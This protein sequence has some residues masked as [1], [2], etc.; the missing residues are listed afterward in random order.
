MAMEL[1]RVDMKNESTVATELPKEWLAIGGSGLIAKIM[2]DE[3]PSG[4][5]PLGPDNKLVIACGPLAGTRAPQLGRISVGAK[6][7]L[8]LGIKEA[9]A[10]GPAGQHMDRLGFRAIVV[11]NAAKQEKTFYLRIS[12]KGARL[13]PA[14]ELEGLKNYELV[15]RLHSR[16]GKKVAIVCIG[17][18]GERKYRGAS[19]SFTDI[20]GDPSRN[21]ARGGLGAVMGSKGLKAI[22]LDPAGTLPLNIADPDRFKKTVKSWVKTMA[23]D[24]SCGLYSKYG[25]PFA[26][27]NSANQG[28]LPTLNYRSGRPRDFYRISG[29]AIQEILFKRGGRM[30]GCMPGCVVKCSIIY[31]D[32]EGNRLASAYE[33]ET[34]AMLGAN[35]GIMDLDAIGRLKFMCDDL[36]LDAIEIGSCLG[37]AADAGK[38]EMGDSAAAAELLMEI[39][40]GSAFGRALGNGVV[41]TAKALNV[42]RVPAYKGQ[43]FPGH[44]PRS[45]KGTGVTYLTSPMGADHTAGLT[46]RIPRQKEKQAQNS[47]R[48]QV[49]AATCDTFGYCL[50]SVP[51]GQTSIYDFFADLMNA[52]YG[53]ELTRDDIVEIGKQTLRDQI[54]F[55]ENAEFSETDDF[56]QGFM[57]TESLGPSDQVFDV[58]DKDLEN[59]WDR[60]DAFKVTKKQ[61]E[62]RIPPMPDTLFGIHAVKKMGSAAKRLNMKKALIVSDPVMESMGRVNE[63]RT[64]LERAGITSD[65]FP[66]IEPD[67]PVEL[68]E[69]AGDLYK[70]KGCDGIVGLGGGSSLDAA[71]AIAL[72]VT[73]PGELTEYESIVGGTAKIRPV[74]PPLI[75]I[76]TTSGTGSEVNPYAVIT[77]KQRNVKFMLM[78]N[79][80]I[81][82][83]AVIDPDYC[84]SMPRELTRE[85]GID[86][87]AHCI[88][89]YVALG[90]PYHPYFESMALYGT[91]LIGRSLVKA[92]K[93]PRDLDARMDMC[94]GAMYGGI[95][96]S[97]GLGV[98]HA[99]THVLGAHYHIPH[100]KA[101]TIG[102]TCFV[103]ANKVLCNR[104]FLDLAFMLNGSK[105]L[106]GALL[107][108]YKDLDI[109]A[110]LRDNHIPEEDL[111]KI[112]FYT[113]RDAVNMATNPSPLTERK[114]LSLLED[115][116]E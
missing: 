70:A 97:K 45:V 71:K 111:G 81:P 78:S 90:A 17:I 30:H 85:S 69:T 2:N 62:V 106:E 56:S 5:D 61:W 43:A 32:A 27:A 64:I 47:L 88:E 93:D 74:L 38:M 7:P 80:L 3:V 13:V 10:G 49:Q 86:A 33:Y 68:I 103:R 18:A 16:Y 89:G 82:R 26:V 60:L 115:V 40:E 114:I 95:A 39:E 110:N 37:V 50:N 73:H 66:D 92:Y 41:S 31:P 19:V 44:D 48:S 11:E 108:L 100:G 112:A 51:G 22:V 42:R 15:G 52:R 4:T 109:A 99:I 35:L 6:S 23:H 65:V 58:P 14:D 104:E 96:F 101:S 76:P 72:R 67:P 91:K 105:D 12:K 79:H 25:T 34:I 116:Y 46:Y 29:E 20:F 57:R 9:N 1:L 107:K 36:G 94:M 75:C 8:T 84:R 28:T 102:L 53:M 24:V 77:N 98:G 113:Y 63:I 87:L 83:V 54:R 55:N 21:A 59:F